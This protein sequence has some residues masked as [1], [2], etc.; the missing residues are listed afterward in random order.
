MLPRIRLSYPLLPTTP[1]ICPMESHFTTLDWIV[2]AVY[3]VGTMSIGFYFWIRQKSRSMEGFTVASR[4]LPG[5]VCGLSI[6][7]TFLSSIS[8]LAL[9]GKS[10]S[11]DWSPFVFSLSLPL[12]A[13]IAVTWF[14]PYYRKSNEISAYAHLEHRF[15]AWARVYASFFYLLTQLARMGAVMYLMGLPLNILLGWDIR[16]IIMVT[17]VSVTIYALVGGIVAVIWADALQ[18]IVLMVGAVGCIIIILLDMPEGVGQVMTVAMEHHKFSFGGFGVS[19]VDETFW[20]ILAY[21][22]FIN[23]QNF[24]IDQNFVQRYIAS[25]S[26]REARK[27]LWFGALLYVPVSAV[28]FFIGTLLFVF[29][30]NHPED[31]DEVRHNV[32]MQQLRSESIETGTPGYEAKL[33]ATSAELTPAQIGDKVF[34]HFIGKHLP[35]G[36]TGLLIAAVFA[37]AMSTISTSL[38]SSAT[39]LMNDYY[40]R[41]F[42]PDATE[43]Q[44]MRVLYASTIVW[45]VLGTGAAMGLVSLSENVL[46][47]WWDLS[48][49]FSGG[50]LGL[51]LL[52]MISRVK[53]PAAVTGVL[54]GALV[55][56]WMVF[57]P[58]WGVLP[59]TVSIEHGAVE[60]VAD[61]FS[62]AEHLQ[63]GDQV[64]LGQQHYEVASVASDGNTLALAT[65]FDQESIKDKSMVKI[66]SLSRYR[67]WFN[68]L[69]VVVIGALTILLVGL[70]AGKIFGGAGDDNAESMS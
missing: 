61:G 12:A 60:V 15:G 35:A 17:G 59:G 20:M 65:P 41:F 36:M 1:P 18:A 19:L 27:S 33:A 37:A 14:V 50:I 34:P 28:F 32:A 55:I 47:I 51:F 52:G 44:S 57:S 10:F 49:I 29:Y 67:N 53:S 26:D 21:G 8:F 3:F 13:W 42:N 23:L 9:P 2:L 56:A 70:L 40:K 11:A 58:A 62:F 38:N 64:L 31:L 22:L 68:S 16:T 25:S 45:G 7:A 66:D 43:R 54:V 4:S 39:L 69:L 48:S 6:F 46:D 24:G 30:T 5:W 63:Q